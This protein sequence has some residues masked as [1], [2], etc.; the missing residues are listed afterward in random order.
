MLVWPNSLERSPPTSYSS[1]LGAALSHLFSITDA[2]VS[3]VGALARVGSSH[4]LGRPSGMRV[5][6][7]AQ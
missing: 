5:S 2:W 6:G 3:A 4:G 7:P 1:S